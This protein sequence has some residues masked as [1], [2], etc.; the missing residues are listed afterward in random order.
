MRRRQLLQLTALSAGASLLPP[1]FPATASAAAGAPAYGFGPPPATGAHPRVVTAPGDLPALQ[2]RVRMGYVQ[3]NY[4]DVLRPAALG[5]PQNPDLVK[6]AGGGRLSDGEQERLAKTLAGAAFTAWLEQSPQL[7]ATV[8]DGLLLWARKLAAETSGDFSR[9]THGVGLAYDWLHPFLTE[10]ERAEVRDWLV[11]RVTAYEAY[12]DAQP[13][14]FKPGASRWDNWT[15]HYVGAFGVAALAVEGESGYLDRWYAKAVAAIHD[16]LDNGIGPEGA[17]LE[18]VHYFAYGMWQGAYLVNAMARRGDPVFAHPHLRR[19]PQWW[20]SDLFPWGNDFNS[21]ADTRDVFN[22]VPVVYQL[23]RLAYPDDPRMRW[24]YLNVMR[25]YLQSPEALAAVLWASEL[26]QSD[27]ARTAEHLRLDP[28]QL[29]LHNGLVYLR[30]GWKTSDVYFQ[31]QSDP[32][33]AGPSHAHADRNSFTL[34]GRDRLWI[35]DGGGLFPEDVGHNL[36]FIDGKAQGWYPHR[37]KVLAYEDAG[38]ATGIL[39]DAKAAYDWRA[40]HAHRVEND[41]AWSLVDGFWS[42]P[43]NPVRRAFRS[44]TLVRGARPYVMI[45]DDIRKDDA[46]HDYSWEALVPL[47]TLVVRRDERSVLL[48][49][50]DAGSALRSGTAPLTVPFTVPRAGRYRVWVLAGHA[51]D[52]PWR[53]GSTLALD[54]QAPVTVSVAAEADFGDC[55]QPH[56]LPVMHPGGSTELAAGPHTATITPTGVNV[57]HALLVAPADHDP[58]G[59]YGARAPEGSVT[60]RLGELPAPGDWSRLPADPAY[61]SCLVTVLNPADAR[62]TAELFERRRASGEYWGKTIKLRARVT[63]DE[64]RF[65]VLL[66]PHR[67]GD[68]VPSVTADAGRATVTWPD[69]TV[70]NWRFGPGPGFA[71][72]NGA[73]V[74]LQRGRDRFTLDITYAGLRR[75]TREHVEGRHTAEQLCELLN[76]AEHEDRRGRLE[77]RNAALRSYRDGV[78][79]FDMPR[80]ARDLLVHQSEELAR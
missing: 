36:V 45:S 27:Q 9:T 32:A 7:A 35:M 48:R 14:G 38:W 29:F 70:D 3:Q 2:A 79:G 75:L 46:A 33:C 65:R 57:Y 58:A 72:T 19:V 31:F 50:V 71:A 49:P 10:A 56:W 17:P 62:L 66:Y 1:A 77:P 39:G 12:L 8:R 40:E 34:A 13:Y 78:K 68:P 25:G 51:Y 18:L 55:A 73:A 11:R 26:D 60:V 6:L 28:S 44:G 67:H 59:P 20:T 76:R 30:S 64:P 22:G 4:A 61:P 43:Y 37:G 24:V 54:G 23:M 41:P 80:A 53:W 52:G 42:Q 16:F 47:G 63:T 21:L 69:G 74:R 15:P 5:L